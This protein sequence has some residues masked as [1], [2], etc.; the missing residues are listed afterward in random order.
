MKPKRTLRLHNTAHNFLTLS[1][2]KLPSTVN[3]P[4]HGAR[5][6][7]TPVARVCDLI[8]QPDLLLG[9]SVVVVVLTTWR[10]VVVIMNPLHDAVGDT[11]SSIRHSARKKKLSTMNNGI[12]RIH[13]YSIFVNIKFLCKIE[14]SWKFIFTNWNHF[15]Q[16]C[17]FFVYF[18]MSQFAFYVWYKYSFK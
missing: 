12:I 1:L 2:Q 8:K 4:V 9:P 14:N 10:R 16:L 7:A 3:I 17:N 13:V 11:P 15:S 6:F 18:N 5:I